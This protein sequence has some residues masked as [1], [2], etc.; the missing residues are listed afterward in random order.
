MKKTYNQETGTKTWHV[1]TI[2]QKFVYIIGMINI[3]LAG[4]ALVLGLFG[5]L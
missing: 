1:E 4:F 2:W 3:I 5:A